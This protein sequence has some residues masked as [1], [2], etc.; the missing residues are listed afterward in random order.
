MRQRRAQKV[1]NEMCAQR[2]PFS[3]LFSLLEQFRCSSNYG[4]VELWLF[5]TFFPKRA[6]SKRAMISLLVRRLGLFKWK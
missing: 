5:E 4:Q 3:R 1:G 2:S 6:R